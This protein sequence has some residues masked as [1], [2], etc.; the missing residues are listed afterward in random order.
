MALGMRIR[1]EVL[2]GRL[3]A[4]RTLKRLTQEAAA[5]ALGVARTTVVA[6]EA[7]RR[8]ISP[9]ELRAFAE[10]Y[11]A[12]EAELLDEERAELKLE[13]DFR[14]STNNELARDEAAVAAM[15]HRLAGSAVQLE[16]LVGQRPTKL[17]L[18]EIGISS[19]GS[20]P[21][22]AEDAA[23]ALRTRLGIGLGP[24]QDLTALMEFDLG[25]RVFERPLPSRISGAVAYDASAGAFVLLNSLH[26]L[27]RRRVTAGHEIGHVLVRRL[28]LS[29]LFE[30][31]K[32][33]AREER[34]FDLFGIALLA[35]ASAVRKKADELQR[36]FSGFSVR[37][38]L[39][40]AIFFN[41]SI[42]AM[43]RRMV[44]LGLLKQGTYEQLRSRRLGLKHRAH[45]IEEMPAFEEAPPFTPRTLLLASIALQRDLLSEQQLAS[46]LELDLVS[47]RRAFEGALGDF[48][49]R[50]LELAL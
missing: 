39:M 38:L 43:T 40:M 13:V 8:P 14:T 32:P 1:P 3:K 41:V 17:D 42:E 48:K 37:Q 26:P 50:A 47:V 19:T 7:G 20:I 25:M 16:K 15:L 22:Q 11:G 35:P 4:A 44:Q 28:G 30:Q 12:S 46:M 45:V 18:P 33:V 49:E 10:L 36:M 29:I 2:G 24:I 34:F 9:T 27:Y 23:L 21:Q 31:D 5:A 6:L